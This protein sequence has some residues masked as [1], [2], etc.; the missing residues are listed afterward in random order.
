MILTSTTKLFIRILFL[1]ITGFVWLVKTIIVCFI[2][3]IK[4]GLEN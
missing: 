4:D 3:A 2:E 1:P